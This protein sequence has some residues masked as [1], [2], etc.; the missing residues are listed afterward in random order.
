M[1]KLRIEFKDG[2]RAV[3]TMK[4]SVDHM[5]YLRMHGEIYMRSATL[6]QYPK[7]KY[8]PVVFVCDTENKYKSKRKL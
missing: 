4:N 7:M 2:S 3:Y 5:Q 6:Q 8:E 1:K